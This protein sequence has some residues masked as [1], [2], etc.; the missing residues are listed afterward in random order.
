MTF[1]LG[2]YTTGAVVIR[3]AN[4]E[5]LAQL[6]DDGSNADIVEST[7]DILFGSK[8]IQRRLTFKSVGIDDHHCIDW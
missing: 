4:V 3:L 8:V 6:I 2:Y 1:R 7:R 5:L